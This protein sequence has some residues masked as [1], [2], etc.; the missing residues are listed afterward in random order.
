MCPTSVGMD[1]L[2]SAVISH[3][4]ADKLLFLLETHFPHLSVRLFKKLLSSIQWEPLTSCMQ[5]ISIF[6]AY[7]QC[8]INE[9]VNVIFIIKCLLR[10]SFKG[11][12]SFFCL[13]G[14]LQATFSSLT[15]GKG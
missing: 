6:L 11:P 10:A 4:I 3:V 7:N 14:Y 12:F 1:W 2:S 15:Q 9:S 8:A 5:S 13:V